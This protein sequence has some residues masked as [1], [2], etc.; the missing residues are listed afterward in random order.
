M[1]S[2]QSSRLAGWRFLVR[3]S[4][5]A[6]HVH[7]TG[8]VLA[9]KPAAEPVD[10][11]LPLGPH[12]FHRGA[13]TRGVDGDDRGAM[14]VRHRGG[15][16]DSRRLRMARCSA[17]DWGLAPRHRGGPD[18]RGE[19]CRLHQGAAKLE[20]SGWQENRGSVEGSAYGG[21]E[22]RMGGGAT[23]S[24]VDLLPVL[25]VVLPR[26]ADLRDRCPGFLEAA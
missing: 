16:R 14:H 18:Q 11:M 20:R 3:V 15:G 2:D 25:C 22:E 19:L 9:S 8:I 6:V 12:L 7:N 10:G 5:S 1:V 26:I 13:R 4:S 17:N 23:S 24:L 21:D